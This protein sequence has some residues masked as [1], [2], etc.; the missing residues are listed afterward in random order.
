VDGISEEEQPD[1]FHSQGPAGIVTL[2]ILAQ[3]GC[4]AAI[5]FYV[6]QVRSPVA[7]EV[8]SGA[9]GAPLNSRTHGE[10]AQEVVELE[11]GNI[12]DVAN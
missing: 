2:M 7:P 12:S 9:I 6:S 8:D 10:E 3:C 4:L 11:S 5:G 1:D